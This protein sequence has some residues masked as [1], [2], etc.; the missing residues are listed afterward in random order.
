M[1]NGTLVT[2]GADKSVRFWNE[3]WLSYL[4][5]QLLKEFYN[6]IIIIYKYYKNK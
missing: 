5:K 1:K 4:L 2:S 6:K 3:S